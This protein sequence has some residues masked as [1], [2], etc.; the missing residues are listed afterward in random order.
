MRK[1]FKDSRS[2]ESFLALKQFL[3]YVVSPQE[4][5]LEQDSLL[6]ELYTLRVCRVRLDAVD[7][8]D[9]FHQELLSRCLAYDFF[10]FQFDNKPA[11]DLSD[12]EMT[13]ATSKNCSSIFD[14]SPAGKAYFPTIH[15]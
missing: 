13:N 14:L 8:I 5:P 3:C 6:R 4:N 11:S 10:L 12:E 1:L 2:E 7:A 9:A 15:Q